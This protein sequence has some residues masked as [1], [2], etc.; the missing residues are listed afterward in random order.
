M[1]HFI[2]LMQAWVYIM[3]NKPRG[4]LYVGVTAELVLRVWQH[5]EGVV[6]GFTRQYGLKKLVFYEEHTSMLQALQREKNIKHWVRQWKLELVETM[7]PKWDDL[8]R[9]ISRH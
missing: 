8:W 1:R 5:R 6:D 2:S 3:T 4:T 9:E 7:N